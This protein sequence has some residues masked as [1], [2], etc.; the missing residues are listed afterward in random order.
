MQAFAEAMVGAVMSA[1]ICTAFFAILAIVVTNGRPYPR[2]WIRL[3]RRRLARR[4]TCQ[5]AAD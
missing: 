2:L 4:G 5:T 3:W 1:V